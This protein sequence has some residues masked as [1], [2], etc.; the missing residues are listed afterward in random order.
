MQPLP[1]AESLARIGKTLC[2][3][4]VEGAEEGNA[5]FIIVKVQNVDS[6]EP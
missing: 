6:G 1:A 4:T 2:R 3:N 5:F